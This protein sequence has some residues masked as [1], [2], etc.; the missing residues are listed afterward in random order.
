M[1]AEFYD[2]VVFTNPTETFFRQLQQMTQQLEDN[3]DAP[4]REWNDQDDVNALI[5]AQKYLQ[6]QVPLLRERL[7][8]VNTE[9][10]SV[11]DE[12]R[13]AEARPKRRKK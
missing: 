3:E 10:K 2:E 4:L 12:L 1:I 5:E 11:E 6:E 13:A 7:E 8:V 9:L